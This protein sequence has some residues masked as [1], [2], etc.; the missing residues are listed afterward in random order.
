M[1][2]KTA[3]LAAIRQSAADGGATVTVDHNGKLVGLELGRA[4]MALSP[5]E[6]AALV[7]RLA[8]TA[9]A[10]ALIDGVACLTGLGGF[11]LEGI[12]HA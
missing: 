3:E 5:A 9:T 7:R 6:L 4:A 2:S 11:D 10:A 8:A 12:D 1:E